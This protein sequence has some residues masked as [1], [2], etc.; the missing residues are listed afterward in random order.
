[1]NCTSYIK[2]FNV[3]VFNVKILL[4][5]SELK[6]YVSVLVALCLTAIIYARPTKFKNIQFHFSPYLCLIN[7]VTTVLNCLNNIINIL[8]IFLFNK[9]IIIKK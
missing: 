3:L 5:Y 6:V 7:K 4:Q 9:P 1:M 8:N 2:T